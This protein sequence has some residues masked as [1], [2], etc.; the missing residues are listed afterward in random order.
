MR[1]IQAIRAAAMAAAIVL[2]TLALADIKVLSDVPNVM[3]RSADGGEVRALVIGIDGYRHVRQLKGAVADAQDID[4][5]LRRMGTRDITTLIDGQVERAAVLTAIDRLVGRTR[6]NDLVIL[7]IAGHGTQ[8]PEKVKGSEPDGMENV[9]LLTGFEPTAAGS[10]QRILGSEFNHFIRQFELR[11]AKVL[12]VADTCHGGG[13]ARDVD[14]RAGEMSFRQVQ[15]YT[16]PVDTLKPVTT[17]ADASLNELDLDRT[18]FLAA[19]DRKTKAPEVRIPGASTLRGALSYAFARAI[20]GNADANGD[21]KITLKELFTNVRQVVYQLSDQRQNIVTMTAPSRNIDR[22]LAYEMTRGISIVEQP[23]PGAAPAAAPV[24]APAPAATPTPA[25]ATAQA[26][27]AAPRTL[28][29]PA[30]APEPVP[31]NPAPVAMSSRPIR[32]ASLD[33]KD[34]NFAGIEKREAAFEI[35]APIDNP[36]LIWDPKSHDVLAWGDV[37]A[38]RVDKSDLPS[39]IDRAAAVRDLKQLSI[40]APQVIRV[41]PD[42]GLHHNESTVQIVL[43]NVINRSLVL[44]N[45]AGDGTVQ[46]LYPIGSDPIVMPTNE[47]SFQVRVREP[48]GADQIVAVTADQ[49]M[50]P[51]KQA[52]QQSDR[53]RSAAQMIK[54]VQRYAPADARIGSTGLFTAP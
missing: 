14:P 43:S 38:Y 26:P 47:Y 15:M 5:A 50:A 49:P 28:T 32:I 17:P 53:R 39:V 19:V 52:L 24:P 44:F 18:A 27:A 6:P 16:I 40:R 9:F 31:A 13:M 37:I 2:P 51:L 29:S 7:S 33:G 36:D 35:V 4:G 21:G 25:A 41:A 34:A 30:A 46:M 1:S 20:E 10:Q 22:D 11:G 48:F 12:F 23:A 54:M 42:D 45:I 3:L 8:E